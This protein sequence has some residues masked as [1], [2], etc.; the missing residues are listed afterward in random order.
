[1]S[2]SL[3]ISQLIQKLATAAAS[4]EISCRPDQL[5]QKNSENSEHFPNQLASF[6]TTQL[7]KTIYSELFSSSKLT[8]G[9]HH[10][11]KTVFFGNFSQ[12]ADPPPFGNPLYFAFQAIRSNFVFLKKVIFG[13]YFSFQI[14]EQ[15]TPPPTFWE[16]FPKIPYFILNRIMAIISE[17]L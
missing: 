17:Y 16:N 10:L 9:G 2:A 3:E 5:I 4:L 7:I 14:W 8:K 1:M 12:M 6:K 15:G 11:K 13:W